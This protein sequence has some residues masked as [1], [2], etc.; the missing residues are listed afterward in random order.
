MTP[1]VPGPMTTADVA[2]YSLVVVA[3]L[4]VQHA[5][6]DFVHLGGAH[7]D[8]V[9]LLPAA[10]GYIGGPE[11]GAM[12]GFFTGIVTDLLL[13]TT[14]G[15][16]ALVFCMLA[17]ATGAATTGLVRSSWWLAVLTFTAATVAGL[18]AYAILGAVLGTPGMLTADLAPALVVATPAAAV[19]AVPLRALVAWAVPPS[20]P[21][22]A[23]TR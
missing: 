3:V 10:A 22:A 17:F 13:P 7:P 11:R 2:R 16:S 12:V 19:L 9:L 6:L 1:P 21:A 5:L 4:A 20:P 14:F 8:V 15:L 18:V 23:T